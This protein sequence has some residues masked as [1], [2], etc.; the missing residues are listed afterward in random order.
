MCGKVRTDTV[1]R[2]AT[3]IYEKFPNE[4]T[5]DFEHNK[6]ILKKV[7]NYTS[8]HFRNKI[9][10]YITRIR[11]NKQKYKKMEEESYMANENF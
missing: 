2:L 1:K 3:Q 11:V 8:K 7:T 5:V 9:A 6:N 4:F 10:G